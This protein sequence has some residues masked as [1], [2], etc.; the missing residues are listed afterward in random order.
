MLIEHVTHGGSLRAIIVRAGF[1][2][3][4]IEFLT[5]PDSSQQLGFMKRPAG[6][7]VEPHVH[8]AVER[9][10]TLTQE[11]LLIRRGRCRLD[12]YTDARD[13]WASYEL[14]QGDV[15]L[16]A[17][18]GHGLFMLEETELIEVKQGP[19]AGDGDKSRFEARP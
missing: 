10:V 9:T 18:G 13:I 15:V 7:V 17:E 6:Y 5:P 4:G 11:V 12:L 16:L 2:P 14:G 8:L 19:Y 3:E 1:H